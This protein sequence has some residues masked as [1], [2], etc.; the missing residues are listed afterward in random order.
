MKTQTCQ[1]I[2]ALDLEEKAQALDLLDRLDNSLSWVKVGLQMFTRYGPQLLEEI[3]EKNYRIFLDLKLHDIPNTVASAIK[4]LSSCPVEMLTL[5]AS[6]GSEMIAAAKQAR[7][8][9]SSEAKLIAVTIL[10]S[11]NPE[12]LAQ[13]GITT[14]IPEQV[15]K[16]GKLSIESGADGLVCSPHEISVLR[17]NLGGSPL[18][19]TPGIRPKGSD[20][21]DQKRIMTPPEAAALGSSF[22]VVGRPIL[23]APDPQQA[24]IEIQHQL[25]ANG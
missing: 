14:P 2:L 22:I 18:L 7:D 4:S 11:F 12:L 25:S 9:S 1:L 16:L 23:K 21:G 6:G 19:I 13:V 5:H 10:T 3:A 15:Q 17:E 8:D 24:T 20:T